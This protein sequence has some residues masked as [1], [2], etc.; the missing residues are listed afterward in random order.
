MR[1]EGSSVRRGLLILVVLCAALIAQA[2]SFA[3]EQET[4]HASQHCCRLCHI[5]P[6]PILPAAATT[7]V[8]PVYS[9][10][11]LTPPAITGTPRE[12]L[13]STSASRAP[14]SLV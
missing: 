14:P 2:A 1:F 11:W 4:H 13:A 5:G 7:V 6:L 8:A 12:V 3:A 10:V 9:S